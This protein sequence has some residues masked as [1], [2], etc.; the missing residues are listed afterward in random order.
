MSTGHREGRAGRGGISIFPS[1]CPWSAQDGW[2]EVDAGGAP[3][4]AWRVVTLALPRD[5]VM[6]VYVSQL[7]SAITVL[8][9]MAPT[10]EGLHTR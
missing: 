10:G 2:D 7:P 4:M 8:P 3:A 1:R 6:P 9:C 5:L